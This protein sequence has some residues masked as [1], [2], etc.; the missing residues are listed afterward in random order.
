M[1]FWLRLQV[2]QKLA[3]HLMPQ[4]LVGCVPVGCCCCCYLIWHVKT[5]VLSH[6]LQQQL[7]LRF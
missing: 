6:A 1:V 4:H 7:L 3:I 2:L 5:A